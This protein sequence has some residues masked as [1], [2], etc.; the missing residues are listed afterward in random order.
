[1]GWCEERRGGEEEE[2]VARTRNKSR[3]L[4]N[5]VNKSQ[6]KRTKDKKE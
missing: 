1:M 5:S 2:E 4:N 6:L 3:H